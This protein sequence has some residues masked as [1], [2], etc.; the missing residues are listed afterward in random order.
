MH[1][2]RHQNSGIGRGEGDTD[3]QEDAE[4]EE[5]MEDDE[6][7]EIEPNEGPTQLRHLT[8]QLREEQNAA[9]REHQY[10]DAA[11]IQHIIL[12]MLDALH[13]RGQYHISEGL[14]VRLLRMAAGRI[15]N[16]IDRCRDEMRPE[17]Q[18]RHY[19]ELHA[20]IRDMI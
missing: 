18:I 9:L 6:A 8:N 14:R 2:I 3:P 4:E 15:E 5:P 7:M 1:L 11:D 12:P 19:L 13:G 16:I 17:L 10:R 20:E